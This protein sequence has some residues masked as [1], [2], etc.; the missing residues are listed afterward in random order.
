MSNEKIIANLKNALKEDLFV[1]I[2]EPTVASKYE[3]K[4]I[5]AKA[6]P[7]PGYNDKI[8]INITLKFDK[9]ITQAII[10]P[11][12]KLTMRPK[13]NSKEININFIP[14]I[15][16]ITDESS[17]S[18]IT[19]YISNIVY[20]LADILSD[21]TVVD[22]IV[23]IESSILLETKGLYNYIITLPETKMSITYDTVD[24]GERTAYTV[25]DR[26][27]KHPQHIKT[28]DSLADAITTI[29][30]LYPKDITEYWWRLDIGKVLIK[31]FDIS[32][33]KV[34]DSC[35]H[36][37][38]IGEFRLPSNPDLEYSCWLKVTKNSID[39]KS[40]LYLETKSLS[41]YINAKV[42][43]NGYDAIV[44][45]AYEIVN[46]I[47]TIVDILGNITIGPKC[48]SLYQKLSTNNG[49]IDILCKFD[50]N[51]LI[52]YWANGNYANIWVTYTGYN[53]P[54]IT[55]GD[56]DDLYIECH[57][58]EKAILKAMDIVHNMK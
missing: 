41:P 3:H 25:L 58:I 9:S 18:E 33:P 17:Y 10:E 22:D 48:E 43:L 55:V 6:I 46:R 29:K 50:N 36:T 31:L 27:K 19:Y 7:I 57:N 53:K 42:S 2:A 44:Y 13:D 35:L 28:V 8:N 37:E 26:F 16:S 20:N 24:G 51:I 45:N 1:Y 34:V 21:Y 49:Y 11:E 5:V 38:Y 14:F 39:E 54:K 4:F 12:S 40:K 47:N 15:F 52:S 56:K 32:E 23:S 30:D